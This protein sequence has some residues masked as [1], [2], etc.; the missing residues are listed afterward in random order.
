MGGW[1]NSN[2]INSVYLSI[3][4]IS[5]KK[6]E[7]KGIFSPRSGFGTAVFKEKL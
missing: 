6:I 5:W 7:T 4:G 1:N 3:E 2:S